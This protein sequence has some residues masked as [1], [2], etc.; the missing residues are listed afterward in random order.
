MNT[1]EIGQ[2]V[3]NAL[4]HNDLGTVEAVQCNGA[5][6]LVVWDDG[7]WGQVDPTDLRAVR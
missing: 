1:F 6:V 7:S 4:L 2:R 3:E 5:V